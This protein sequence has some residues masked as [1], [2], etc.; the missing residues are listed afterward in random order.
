MDRLNLENTKE[1]RKLLDIKIRKALGLEDLHCPEVWK[2]VKEYL[3]SME[4]TEEL[5]E[6][7]KRNKD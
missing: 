5:I 4:K 1:N 6:Q 7:I 3:V 2:V